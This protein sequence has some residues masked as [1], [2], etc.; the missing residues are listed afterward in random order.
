MADE[1]MSTS[2]QSD[3]AYVLAKLR[4]RG[5]DHLLLHAHPK[6]G[7]WSLVGG[8]VEPTDADWYSAA[9]RETEEELTPLELGRDVEVEP[10]AVPQS[11]WG[12]VPSMSAGGAPTRYRARW[13]VL[14]FKADP[15]RLLARLPK[16]QFMLLPLASLDKFFPLS[17]LVKRA[18]NL[19]N[20]WHNL[21][22]DADL[23]EPPLPAVAE[24]RLSL[25]P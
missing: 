1:A 4:I 12:P 2:R 20:G 8:H 21:P 11:E 10:L 15:E 5:V 22:W 6:W 19:L 9:M 16:D 23:A 24:G 25:A 17:S 18:N 3:V 13:Y 14:R 7:D